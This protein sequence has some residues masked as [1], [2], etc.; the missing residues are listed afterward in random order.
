MRDAPV[1]SFTKV[2]S[3]LAK[4]TDAQRSSKRTVTFASAAAASSSARLSALRETEL[5]A[6]VGSAE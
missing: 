1:A 6:R 2:T 4:S 3:P 5:I